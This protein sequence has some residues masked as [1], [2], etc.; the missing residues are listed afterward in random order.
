M[1]TTTADRLR[2]ARASTTKDTRE[3]GALDAHKGVLS[4]GNEI[5]DAQNGLDTA[6]TVLMES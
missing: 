3:G 6:V 2:I 4:L 5:E 1:V